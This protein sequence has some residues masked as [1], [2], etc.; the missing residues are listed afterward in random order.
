MKTIDD[1]SFKNKRAL[2]RVDFNVPLNEKFEITDKTR[3]IAAE[4]TI[5]KILA[6]GGSVVLM[7]HLGRPKGGPEHKFS[8]K[9]LVADLSE[10][11]STKVIFADDCIG[12]AAEKL[13]S[14]LK[15]GEILL[16]ENLRFYKEETAGDVDFAEKLAK[17]GDIYVNDAFGTAHRAHASTSIIARFFKDKVC[18]YVMAAELAN[19]DKVLKKADKPFTAIMG[20]AKISD[21]IQVVERLLDVVDNLI[22]GGGMSYTFSKAMGGNIGKSL[23]ENDKLDLA[24]SIMEKAKQKGVNLMLPLDTVQA[25]DFSNDAEKNTVKAG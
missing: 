16:L 5:K 25:S 20:G 19:A 3:I 11:F 17:H 24:L 1:I 18:G 10:R 4:S 9:H 22:I 15:P 12:E 7:S 14:E 13:S 8:L 6:D 23:C 2:I 21:K